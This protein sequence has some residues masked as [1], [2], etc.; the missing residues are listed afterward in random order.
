MKFGY[1]CALLEVMLDFKKNTEAQ[2]AQMYLN[3]TLHKRL[4]ERFER[5]ESWGVQIIQRYG[6]DDPT[7][8]IND[9]QWFVPL[10]EGMSVAKR[11]QSPP[12]I[13]LNKTD[14]GYDKRESIMPFEPLENY[15]AL[16][17]KVL[18]MKEYTPTQEI[19]EVKI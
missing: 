1:H 19:R 9:L 7:E 11:V 12:N 8:F 5:P 6:L 18:M 3:G 13:A 10:T 15:L 14:Y 4:A 17:D 2:V 16:R